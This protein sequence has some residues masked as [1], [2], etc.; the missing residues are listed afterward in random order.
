MTRL[1]GVLWES[2]DRILDLYLFR[3]REILWE[4]G[5][6][7]IDFDL[8]VGSRGP[9]DRLPCSSLDPSLQKPNYTTRWTP[10]PCPLLGRVSHGRASHHS[11]VGDSCPWRERQGELYLW[12][13]LA[14][15]QDSRIPSG[16]S[17]NRCWFCLHPTASYEPWQRRSSYWSLS[18]YSIGE[19]SP[20][21]HV[22][23]TEG[24]YDDS[25]NFVRIDSGR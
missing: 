1:G 18:G 2:G 9:A 24:S 25:R 21:F 7:T 20:G 6:K 15:I 14:I 12:P 19:T 23:F 3:L 17:L 4:S 13:V 11:R 22:L 8:L 10:P 16:H 5:A